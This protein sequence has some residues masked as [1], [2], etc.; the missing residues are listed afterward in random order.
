MR[1]LSPRRRKKQKKLRPRPGQPRDLLLL[2]L[3]QLHPP[4]L[5]PQCPLRP[6]QLRIRRRRL[7]Q[8]WA[9]DVLSRQLHGRAPRHL[10]LLPQLLLQ[11]DRKLIPWQGRPLHLAPAHLL[12]RLL[13][14]PL[15]RQ[16]QPLHQPQL[17]LL[18]QP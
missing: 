9:E 8:P 10:L 12:L 7:R 6:V 2:R 14:R 1:K 16:S 4:L 11:P 17:S 3:L 13:R 18:C 15:V 5:R